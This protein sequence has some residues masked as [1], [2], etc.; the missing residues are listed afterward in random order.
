MYS[1]V[2]AFGIASVMLCVGMVLRGKIKV[3]QHMLMPVSVIGGILGFILVNLIIA[4]YDIGG[5]TITDFSNI[6]DVF[7]VMSFI[8]I[9]LTGSKKKKSKEPADKEEKRNSSGPVRGAMGMALIWCILYAVQAI[10]GV[11]IVAAMGKPFN[12]DAMYGILIPFAFCQGPGQSSTYGKLFEGT[13]GFANAE[14]VALT[15]AVCGFLSAFLLGVPLAKLGLKKGLAKNKSKIND[16]VERGYFVPEEQREP[17][18]KSTFHSANIET[19]A[20]HF[21]IMGVCYLLALVLAKLFS[22]IPV[23]GSTLAAM[24]FMWGM[25]AAYI[26][27]GIM[28]KLKIDYLIN[29]MFQSRITGFLS[30]YLVICAFMAIQVGVIGRWLIPIIVVSVVSAFLTFIICLYFGSRLGSDHDFERVLGV[31]GTCTGT[32]PSGVSLIR[33]VDP[34]LQTPTGVELGMMNMAMILSTPTMLL[35]TFAGLKMLSLGVACVGMFV[36]ILIYLVLLKMFRVWKKPTF[37]FSKGRLLQ[38]EEE[39]AG[40]AVLRGYLYSEVNM[41]NEEVVENMVNKSWN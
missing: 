36:T 3:F 27:K 39:A 20:A 1:V 12:M 13:Y 40:M 29:N 4:N 17:V 18:G 34:K 10:A 32:T 30:D 26:V 33:I 19:I 37:S 9:G 35:I 5:V 41:S 28:R 15:F 21:A 31:Y 38:G 8:S 24:L 11:I 6:V 14:M 7:F 22:Y 25:L 23:F 16:A 2:V